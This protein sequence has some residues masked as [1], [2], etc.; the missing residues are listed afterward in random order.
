MNQ[1]NSAH[2]AIEIVVDANEL[3]K[4][5]QTLAKKHE[6]SAN[7]S[8]EHMSK[9][10]ETLEAFDKANKA[11]D[12]KYQSARIILESHK[13]DCLLELQTH[14]LDE[15]GWSKHL[16]IDKKDCNDIGLTKAD[17]AAIKQ[18]DFTVEVSVP[19]PIT[20]L[21]IDELLAMMDK[22]MIGRPST[23]ANILHDITK[24]SKLL[25]IDD[26]SVRL[27][28][29]GLAMAKHLDSR[30]LDEFSPAFNLTFAQDLEKI[31]T[32]EETPFNMLKKYL[33]LVAQEEDI[34]AFIE[35]AWHT[36]SDINIEVY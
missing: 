12:S 33:P 22:F 8:Y 23:Y 4:T 32:G 29:L 27:T 31:S 9:T 1:S 15:E 19:E 21:T 26:N 2:E 20:N 28:T 7:N 13:S 36:L 25:E 14:V 35:N 30:A 6:K 17:L 5:R 10:L 34:N 18:N 24:E 11:G 3:E 16:L